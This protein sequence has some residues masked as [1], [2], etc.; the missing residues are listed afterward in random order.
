MNSTS[1]L[2][3]FDTSPKE[4]DRNV[5]FVKE[6]RKSPV[7]EISIS[8]PNS[9]F[10]YNDENLNKAPD[11]LQVQS[12]EFKILFDEGKLFLDHS[13]YESV[14][15]EKDKVANGF[16]KTE[17]N[18]VTV[19]VKVE[20]LELNIQEMVPK[21]IENAQ[22]STI[23]TKE[24]N[25]PLQCMEKEHIVNCNKKIKVECIFFEEIGIKETDEGTGLR[26]VKE[27]IVESEDQKVHIKCELNIGML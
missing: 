6:E 16:D 2:S 14:E 9:F 7:K 22:Y 12:N 1:S 25:D 13:K 11:A 4:N 15:D 17:G 24:Q 26:E 3:N 18:E 19:K 27:E 23:E 5:V 8:S 10:V 21:E 20:T